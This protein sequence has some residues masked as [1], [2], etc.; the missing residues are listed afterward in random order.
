MEQSTCRFP[1]RIEFFKCIFHHRIRRRKEMD[2][3]ANN[4]DEKCPFQ[5]AVIK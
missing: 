1:C 2:E 5:R 4:N 3:V